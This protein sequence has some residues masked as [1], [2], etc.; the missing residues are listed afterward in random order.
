MGVTS[1]RFGK[2]SVII[3]F[4]RLRILSD[5]CRIS[6]LRVFLWTS[7]VPWHHLSLFCWSPELSICFLLFPLNPVLN[8]FWG[9]MVSI[10]F[11][12]FSLPY[13]V[14]CNNVLDRLVGGLNHLFSFPWFNFVCGFIGFLVLSVCVCVCVCVCVFAISFPGLG[15]I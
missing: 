8:Y 9:G 3:L 7:W 13:L 10:P 14:L 4:N 12:F 1:S 11:F 6:S 5:Y 15:V 2:F